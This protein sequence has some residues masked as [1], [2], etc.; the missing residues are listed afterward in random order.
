MRYRCTKTWNRDYKYYGGRG[1]KVCDRWM[2]SFENFLADLGEAPM[3]MSLERKHNDK[4]YEPS[5]CI[6]ARNHAQ[7]RNKRTTNWFEING[8]TKTIS[9]WAELHGI[10]N[11]VL[12]SRIKRKWPIER[13][14]IPTNPDVSYDQGIK[15][16][17]VEVRIGG[18]TILIVDAPTVPDNAKQL[19]DILNQMSSSLSEPNFKWPRFY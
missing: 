10:D 17:Q 11:S 13:L 9:E 18:R 7:Q 14:F 2:K 5:N 12:R 6:W 4:N 1:I 16:N 15:E 3:G 8:V 19:A